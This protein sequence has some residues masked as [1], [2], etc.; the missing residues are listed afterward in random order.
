MPT[1]C[2]VC[3]EPQKRTSVGHRGRSS[4]CQEPTSSSGLVNDI[5]DC[6]ELTLRLRSSSGPSV[7]SSRVGWRLTAHLRCSGSS[8]PRSSHPR[9][10][11]KLLRRRPRRP[12]GSRSGLQSWIDPGTAAGGGRRRP[13]GSIA[14]A[15]RAPFPDFNP[16]RDALAT[17]GRSNAPASL[18][19]SERQLTIP[20][21]SLLQRAR[22]G[23]ISEMQAEAIAPTFP[24]IRSGMNGV[25]PRIALVSARDPYAGG[26]HTCSGPIS[27]ASTPNSA[28]SRR[29]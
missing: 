24:T 3:F 19:K 29:S 22:L 28:L 10:T 5:K 12:H 17:A 9:S 8:G 1:Q 25:S 6:R 13:D 26:S 27:T 7:R 11:S 14:G 18:C 23:S 16:L 2:D 4:S 15:A 21:T 20:E